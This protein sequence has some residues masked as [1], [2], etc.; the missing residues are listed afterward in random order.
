MPQSGG[1]AEGAHTWSQ[2]QWET[3]KAYVVLCAAASVFKAL[4][5]NKIRGC[6][7]LRMRTSGGGEGKEQKR[8]LFI[9]E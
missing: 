7:G 4:L 2:V 3:E 8:K 9:E 6:K 1:Q 5:M